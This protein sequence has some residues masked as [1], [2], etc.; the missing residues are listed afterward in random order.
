MRARSIATTLL[1]LILTASL[2]AGPAHAQKSG[3]TLRGLLADNPPSA[4]LHEEITASVVVP[5][6]AV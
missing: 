6:M 1:A 3:G 4:S 5:L 2:A